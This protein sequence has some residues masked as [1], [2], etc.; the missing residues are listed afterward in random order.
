M[1]STFKAINAIP[2]FGIL[3]LLY[4]LAS[5]IIDMSYPGIEGMKG[6]MELKLHTFLLPSTASWQI[7]VSDVIILIGLFVLYIEL[8]KATKAS[9][10]TIYEHILS[11]FVFLAYLLIFLYAPMVANSTFVILGAMSFID[12]VAGITITIT[13]ARRDFSVG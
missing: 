6:A 2:L 10:T 5:T 8:F 9:D 4:F 7:K 13:A 11:L 3:L 12:V 1:K